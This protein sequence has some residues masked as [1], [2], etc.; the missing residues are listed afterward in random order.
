VPPFSVISRSD[1]PDAFGEWAA[2]PAFA[3]RERHPIYGRMG[4]A[5][6]AA[7]YSDDVDTSFAVLRGNDAPVALVWCNVHGGTL[8]YFGMPIRL[9]IGD[10]VPDAAELTEA[11]LQELGRVAQVHD[12]SSVAVCEDIRCAVLSPLGKGCVNRGARAEVVQ[13]GICDLSL[14]EAAF[15]RHIR[16]SFQSLLNTGRRMMRLAYFNAANPD[17]SLFEAYRAFHSQV[18]GRVTRSDESWRA[19]FELIVS[20]RGELALGYLGGDELVSGTMTF[21]GTEIAYYA[22]GVYDRTRFDKP[23]AHFPLYDAIMRSGNRG[24]RYFDLGSLPAR[25]AVSDKEYNIGYFKR[26]F[27]TAVEMHFVWRWTPNQQSIA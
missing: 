16:K 24:L 20:G 27:A 10:N 25:D 21:D 4:Y 19:M 14:D 26:G 7:T 1:R 2:L 3:G 9:F 6:Y 5:Y 23:L 15:R 11:A 13:H 17:L 12:V 8:S 18:A 22:S